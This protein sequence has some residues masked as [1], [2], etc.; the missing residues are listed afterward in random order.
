MNRCNLERLK[1]W[2]RRINLTGFKM[3]KLI[4][5]GVTLSTF[6]TIYGNSDKK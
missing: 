1:L 4:K 5:K 3:F 2:K 6:Q